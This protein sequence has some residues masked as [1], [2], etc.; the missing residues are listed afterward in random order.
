[1]NRMMFG[2]MFP[3]RMIVSPEMKFSIQDFTHVLEDAERKKHK[4]KG[5]DPVS[6]MIVEKYGHLSDAS[7]YFFLEAFNSFQI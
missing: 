3:I 4:E 1:M 2:G 6:K 5:R 7:D